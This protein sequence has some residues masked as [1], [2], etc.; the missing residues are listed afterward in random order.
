GQHA[1]LT[2]R[3]ASFRRLRPARRLAAGQRSHASWLSL[4][5]ILFTTRR[6]SGY[7]LRFRATA[8]QND[9]VVLHRRQAVTEWALCARPLWFQLRTA[10]DSHSI[11]TNSARAQRLCHLQSATLERT[12]V[13][14]RSTLTAAAR[15]LALTTEVLRP[16]S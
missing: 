4:S 10:S 2:S 6:L 14:F 11:V 15:G 12:C 7:C 1:I 9:S 8:C 3:F 13:C 5:A 16:H